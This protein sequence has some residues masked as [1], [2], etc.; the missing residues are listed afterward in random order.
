MYIGVV[1]IAIDVG[2][3]NV[4]IAHFVNG[5]ITHDLRLETRSDT[6]DGDQEGNVL[7]WAALNGILL[8]RVEKVVIASVVPMQTPIWSK[9]ARRVFNREP[10]IVSSA[11]KLPIKL[12]VTN[13]SQLGADLIVIVDDEQFRLRLIFHAWAGKFETSSPCRDRWRR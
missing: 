12:A 3:S 4:K 13:P 11:L 2:N 7:E 1:L 10:I 6:V 8:E 9:V 5:V